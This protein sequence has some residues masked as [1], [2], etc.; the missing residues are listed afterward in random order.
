VAVAGS[1]AASAVWAFRR[2]G[3]LARV[4]G[5]ERARSLVGGAARVAVRAGWFSA[6][7]RE[8]VQA[9]ERAEDRRGPGPVGG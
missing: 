9:L 7:S 1:G 4:F 3:S 6:V 8:R 2:L 5:Q